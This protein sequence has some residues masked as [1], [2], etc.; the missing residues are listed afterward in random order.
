MDKVLKG[1]KITI[2]N[3]M[4]FC[5]LQNN[6]GLCDNLSGKNDKNN[7]TNG[8]GSSDDKKK[9]ETPETPEEKEKKEL[10]QFRNSV[11]Q[12]F[13]KTIKF[14]KDNLVNLAEDNKNSQT[15]SIFDKNS[16]LK[17]NPNALP[18]EDQWFTYN[19]IFD[20]HFTVTCINR[21]FS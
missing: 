15:N 12:D 3:S 8:D 2:L 11:S 16:D 14:K 17:V 19:S 5:N 18:N 13:R 6:F 9:E 4:I 20:F 1:L 10:E 21:I 7:G